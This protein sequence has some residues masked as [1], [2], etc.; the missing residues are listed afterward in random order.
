[1][2]RARNIK[3]GFFKNEDLVELPFEARLLFIGLW[4]LADREGRLEDRPKRVKMEVFPADNVDIDLHLTQLNDRGLIHRY[5]DGEDNYIYITNFKKHQNPHHLEKPSVIPAPGQTLE[6]TFEEE[7]Q[8]SDDPPIPDGSKRA[9]SLI[10]E[11]LNQNTIG[12][13]QAFDRFWQAYPKKRKKKTAK[14][15]W[16]RKRMDRLIDAI[17]ED[18]KTR[19]QRDSRWLQGFVPDPTTYL[20]QERWEDEIEKPKAPGGNGA[21][22]RR[23]EDEWMQAGKRLGLQPKVGESMVAYIQ[24]I[25]ARMDPAHA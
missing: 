14:E 9:D 24:R 15:I 7:G 17:L 3:P 21:G 20:N 10:P 13:P 19:Q 6:L 22:S 1:M 12:Q 16:K 5:S 23:T 11:S 4:C 25:Q 8:I 18:I 2:A